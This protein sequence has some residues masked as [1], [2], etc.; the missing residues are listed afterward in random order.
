MSSFEITS[1]GINAAYYEGEFSISGT[2]TAHKLDNKDDWE[3]TVPNIRDVPV[4]WR[5]SLTDKDVFT[6]YKELLW[7]PEHTTPRLQHLEDYFARVEKMPV[8][9]LR[10]WDHEEPIS[11]AFH[12]PNDPTLAAFLM[13]VATSGKEIEIF[14]H[15]WLWSK[16]DEPQPAA[17]VP[18]FVYRFE[19]AFTLQHPVLSMK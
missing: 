11:L 4:H 12:Y 19:P 13:G 5:I 10:R 18:G 8:G 9:M 1:Q 3:W 7:K 16:G 15:G 2:S 14:G 17:S 6:A